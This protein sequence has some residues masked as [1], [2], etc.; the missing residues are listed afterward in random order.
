M[1]LVQFFLVL[2]FTLYVDSKDC[3]FNVTTACSHAN[4]YSELDGSCNNLYNSNQAK[5]KTPYKRILPAAYEDKKNSPR[6]LDKQRNL[7][8][9]PRTLSRALSQ[10]NKE[11]D[12]WT[13]VFATFGQ[14]ITHD[15]SQVSEGSETCTC[16]SKSTECMNIHLPRNDP[17]K[18]KCL[19]FVRSTLTVDFSCRSDQREQLNL[20]TPILDASHV[21]G[22]SREES[23]KLRTLYGG[24]LASTNG[25]AHRRPYLPRLDETCS[26]FNNPKMKCFKSGDD[27]T[28]QNLAL[29]TMHTMFLREHN[30]IAGALAR[31][32]KHWNDDRLFYESRRI[33]IAVYQHIIYDQYIASV[34]GA[35]GNK[36]F[37]LDPTNSTYFYGYDSSVNPS[38]YNE[39]VAAAM[40]FGHTVVNNE[41]ARFTSKNTL[42][43]TDL[44]LS[45]INFKVEEAYK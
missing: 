37:D 35:D 25:V 42:M 44:T 43:D 10:D 21:Y 33:M 4:K 14:F 23:L 27:R 2:Y 17:L 18:Q 16:D 39:F 9:N 7:L 30:R 32:N 11:L 22:K 36:E 40:R 45:R 31:I 13:H 3:I 15:M 24:L 5:T 8:P 26:A 28:T 34:I 20:A 6:S 29:T 38:L 1:L 41:F 19:P 12:I